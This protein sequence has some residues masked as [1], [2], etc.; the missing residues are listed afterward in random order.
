MFIPREVDVE[1]FDITHKD[2]PVDQNHCSG[3][4]E[5]PMSFNFL[6][7]FDGDTL[8]KALEKSNCNK[9]VANFFS[10]PILISSMSL[11]SAD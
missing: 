6:R 10:L 7:S 5:K 4:L 1:D 9:T 3:D 8:S 11:I 2:L